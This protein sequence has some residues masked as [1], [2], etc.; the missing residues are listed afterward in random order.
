MLFPPPS[1]AKPSLVERLGCGNCHLGVQPWD[2][3]KQGVPTLDEITKRLRPDYVLS[4]LAKKASD[5][6]MPRVPLSEVEAK[7]VVAALFQN[8]DQIGAPWPTKTE[9]EIELAKQGLGAS[10]DCASCHDGA[11]TDALPLTSMG[12]KYRYDAMP[13]ILDTV[14]DSKS[15]CLTKAK[16]MKASERRDL[17][18]ALSPSTESQQLDW[19]Q[20]AAKP[21]WLAA[22]QCENCHGNSAE[23][24]LPLGE[25]SRRLKPDWLKGYLRQSDP[26][27]PSGVWSGDGRRMPQYRLSESD[28]NLL[29]RELNQLAGRQAKG[30]QPKPLSTGRK[31][32]VSALL[33]TRY[34]CEGCHAFEGEGGRVGPSLDGV[35]N[36]LRW[37]ALKAILEG[38]SGFNPLAAHAHGALGPNASSRSQLARY[39]YALPRSESK[40]EYIDY[41]RLKPRKRPSEGGS[42]GE[43]LYVQQCSAC[44]GADGGGRG[45][46]AAYLRPPPMVHKQQPL[47]SLST[48][49]RLHM[50]LSVGGWVLGKSRLMPGFAGAL[51]EAQ[52]RAIVGHLRTLCEC[53]PPAWSKDVLP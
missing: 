47:L 35:G 40:T 17:L 8:T 34:A 28:L 10:W 4:L 43:V 13:S 19:S 3:Q 45:F 15:D 48:D 21:D 30:R 36:R 53:E 41:E 46:N 44:H 20:V 25:I 12:S 38:Y 42:E 26:I 31:R 5:V 22:A 24:Y 18:I 23:R 11:N 33:K 39:L 37:E 1:V 50:A 14:F 2:F 27:R 6:K 16:E 7:G 32:G 51:S 29:T 52:V 9:S 49:E